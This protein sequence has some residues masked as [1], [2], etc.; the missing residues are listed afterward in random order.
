MFYPNYQY[1]NFGYGDKIK[2]S[3]IPALRPVAPAY[4]KATDGQAFHFKKIPRATLFCSQNKKY[5]CGT[6]QRRMPARRSRFG[7]GGRSDGVRGGNAESSR[8]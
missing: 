4:A 6:K 3:E 7:V 2:K 8:R 5:P 1:P